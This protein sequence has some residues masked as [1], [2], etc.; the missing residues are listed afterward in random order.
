ML[1]ATSRMEELRA[2]LVARIVALGIDGNILIATGFVLGL[3]A[4]P[5]IATGRG[6]A[7]L[8]VMLFGFTL[9]AVGRSG[10]DE[11]SRSLSATLDIIVLAGLLFAFALGDPSHALAACF[12]MFGLIAAGAASLFAVSHRTLGR[13]DRAICLGAF[14]IACVFPLWFGLI[15]Y[16]L[17]IFCFVAAG[18]RVALALT[19]GTA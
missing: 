11:R 6:W 4:M 15:A 19:R 17:G 8:P 18:A 5:L 10:A 7:A 12:A 16:V 14:A 9:A 1:D 13:L 3:T 2:Q